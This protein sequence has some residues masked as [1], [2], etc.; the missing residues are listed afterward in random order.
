[1]MKKNFFNPSRWCLP[2]IACV[3]SLA[4]AYAQNDS[5]EDLINGH[6]SG[7]QVLS[8]DGAPGSAFSVRIRGLKS[9]RGNNEPLYVLD[10]VLLNSPMT[11]VDKTFWN[12]GADYQ[13]LQNTL[14][15]INPEDIADI[16]ILKDAAATAIYGSLGG[17]GVVI[18]TTKK[19]NAD[20]FKANLKTS[21]GINDHA[22]VSHKHH[23]AIEGGNAK[24]SYYVSA[25]YRQTQGSFKRS[26]LDLATID[27]RYEQMFGRTSRFGASVALGMRDNAMVMATSPLGAN[28]TVKS[29]WAVSPIAFEGLD[30]W[31]KGYDDNSRQYSVIPHLYLDAGLGAGF[32]FKV[33]AGVDFRNK[34]RLRFVSSTLERARELKGLAGQTNG[35]IIQYNADA[36]FSYGLDKNKHKVD[37]MAGTQ[38]TGSLFNEYIHEGYTFF[39][40]NLR[41]AGISLAENVAPY[42]HVTN[43]NM[44]VAIVAT[45]G[46]NYDNR[47]FVNASVRS[48]MQM[49][50]DQSLNADNLYPSASAAWNMANEAFMKEQKVVNNFKL[51]FGWG[52]SG[53]QQILPYG[54]DEYY[55][56]GLTPDFYE[57]GL[58]NYYTLRWKSVSEQYNLG[59]DMGFLEDRITANVNLYRI[60]T[61]DNMGYF[62]HVPSEGYENVFS[63]KAEIIN[64][65][66]EFS[67][68][69]DLLRI[70]DFVWNLG[71]NYAFNHNEIIS[72]DTDG[73]ILGHSV[74]KW[75]NQDI[76]TNAARKGYSVGSFYGYMSQGLVKKEHTLM[77]PA[78]LGERLK[79]G[80]VKFID[81]NNDGQ[82]DEDDKT[83]IGSSLPKHLLSFDTKFT[84]KGLSVYALFDG[85]FGHKMANLQKFYSDPNC[86]LATAKGV[87]VFSSRLL[88]D[89]S[90][91]RLANLTASYTFDLKKVKWM[92]SIGISFSCKNLFTITKYSGSAPYANSYGYDLS[93]AGVDNGAYPSYR[94]F[95][96]GL[97]LRF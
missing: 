84:W 2:A 33:N 9:F 59:L 62:R 32:R 58:T 29:A 24:S 79:E 57:G 92:D 68:N 50:Y 37:I 19:G 83:I 47:Y 26:E 75:D 60:R 61:K 96:L 10:G 49:K 30:A 87:D 5:I 90:Y 95:L 81:Q 44:N 35:N 23:V 27:A 31:T 1:M 85:A 69:A 46:Y 91:L 15:H 73:A 86:D 55:T 38:L 18:I 12:D 74:G 25:G 63:D 71:V 22:R 51:S 41:G 8:N 64:K 17:N 6:T 16:Q 45:A 56:S 89:A 54:Y 76:I 21:V 4:P 43:D 39:N 11:D 82:V 14:D 97:N 40:E 28:S 20:G 67:V 78:F 93:R 77:T 94:S 66:V 52:M 80:D 72:V 88:E 36:A 42:R 65:G 13:T 53:A 48:E 3:M 34:T 7:V 70:H